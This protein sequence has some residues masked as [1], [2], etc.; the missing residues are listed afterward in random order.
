MREGRHV[1]LVLLVGNDLIQEGIETRWPQ[2]LYRLA[3][4]GVGNDLIQEGI[5][6]L[7]KAPWLKS[8]SIVGNDLIQEGIET[9]P[10]ASLRAPP[11]IRRG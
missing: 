9:N 2:P 4:R 1:P 5:E 8:R 6:T 7:E 11:G 3:A 10:S